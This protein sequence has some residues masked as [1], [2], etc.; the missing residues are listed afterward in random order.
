MMRPPTNGPGRTARR[1]SEL[2]AEAKQSVKMRQ[3][4]LLVA[5]VVTR[6]GTGQFESEEIALFRLHGG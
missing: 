3:S 5:A 1:L 4:G 6:A 2:P